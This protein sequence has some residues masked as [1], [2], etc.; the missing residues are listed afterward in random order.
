MKNKK[1]QVSFIDRVSGKT[2]KQE[3]HTFNE[4]VG[5]DLIE[6]SAFGEEEIIEFINNPIVWVEGEN[7]D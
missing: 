2:I 4:L 3:E 7:N 6:D 1:L 5:K